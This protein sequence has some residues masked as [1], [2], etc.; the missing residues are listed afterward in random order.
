T[1]LM[2]VAEQL[3]VEKTPLGV[4]AVVDGRLVGRDLSEGELLRLLE[5]YPRA[6]VVVSPLGGQGFILGRGN[7]QISPEV[8]RRVGRENIIVL[9]TK[10]K[11]AGLKV[12][13]VDTGDPEVDR[14]L[15]G[16]MRVI[17]DY[18]EERVVRVA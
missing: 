2:A 11:M 18:M 13:R 15:R 14:M 16:Y 5:R 12:L 8:L 4:D 1:T 7:Q 6:K 3:G 17:V 10:D 9:A